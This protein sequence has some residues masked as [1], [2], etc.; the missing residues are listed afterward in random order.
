MYIVYWDRYND[1]FKM[2][3]QIDISLPGVW[4]QVGLELGEVHVEGAVEPQGGR[5]GG[6]DLA[7]QPGR[8]DRI[9]YAMR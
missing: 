7:D 5:D 4:D 6:H 9:Y 2:N 8:G 3:R 1:R